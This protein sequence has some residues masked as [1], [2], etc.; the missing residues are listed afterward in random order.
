[1]FNNLGVVKVVSG[2]VQLN[3]GQD[4]LY[5]LTTLPVGQ[6]GSYPPPPPSRPFPLPYKDDF[7]GYHLHDEPF[8]LAQQTGSFEVL[9]SESNQFLRQMVLSPP[10]AW[11]EAENLNKAVNIIGNSTWTDLFVEV[12]FSFPE[13]NFSSG[14]F[15]AARINQGGCDLAKSIGIYLFVESANKYTLANDPGKY[16]IITSG[17]LPAGGG[18]HK[19]SLL[20]QGQKAYGAYD[21]NGLFNIG[22]PNNPGSGFAGIGT[23]NFGLADFDNLYIAPGEEGI[24]RMMDYFHHPLPQPLYVIKE[25]EPQPHYVIK[26]HNYN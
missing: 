23:D 10:I 4:E 17:V 8:N 16:T 22:I 7:E 26:E 24:K 18:W 3:L 12:D 20:V 14:V 15:V 9:K 6:K 11:C 1:M 5:T 2:T 21:G 13:V 25:H 19:L